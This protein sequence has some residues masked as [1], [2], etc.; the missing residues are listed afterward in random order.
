MIIAGI[1]EA[2]RGC[3]MGSMVVACVALP[4]ERQA[5]LKARG[6]R[7]SKL[8]TPRRRK[9]LFDILL[10]EGTAFAVQFV[11]PM[12]IDRE[13]LNHLHADCAVRLIGRM[14]ADLYFLDAPV[15]P[16]GLRAYGTMLRT[17]TGRKVYPLNKAD[18]RI[19]VVAAASIIAKVV[20][21]RMIA[22][23]KT[24][25]GDFGSGYPSDPATIAWLK[26]HDALAR[27]K[28]VLREKWNLQT[29]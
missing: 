16:R 11:T 3:C 25:Y 7:D 23:L 5:W 29:A 13:N 20:R 10:G 15:P 6:V 21:D 22:Y 2:G 28:R 12:E 24:A 18:V 1:D 19:P 17:Q 14:P 4:K 26:S 8:L 9:E 27:R